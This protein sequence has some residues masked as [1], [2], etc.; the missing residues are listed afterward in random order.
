MKNSVRSFFLIVVTTFVIAALYAPKGQAISQ[1]KIEV[2]SPFVVALVMDGIALNG[3]RIPAC[4]GALIKSDVVVTAAH[5]VFKTKYIQD[6]SGL[7]VTYPGS[8]V[9]SS[10]PPRLLEVSKVLPVPTFVGVT[11]IPNSYDVDDIAFLFLKEPIPDFEEVKIADST[12]VNRAKN[13]EYEIKHYGYGIQKEKPYTLDGNPYSVIL[14]ATNNPVSTKSTTAKDERVL[15]SKGIIP[16]FATCGG[17]SGGPGYVTVS[18]VTYLVSV[19]AG[20]GGCDS[21]IYLAHTFSNLIFPHIEFFKNE[22]QIYTSQKATELKVKQEAEK[23]LLRDREIAI[24]ENT[25]YM[26]KTGC[27]WNG[28]NAELQILKGGV[29]RPLVRAKGWDFVA[30]CPSSHPVQPWTVAEIEQISQL[31]W[32]YWVVG[33]FDVF[34]S[35]FQSQL[36]AKAV[37]DLKAKQEAETEAA[38]DKAAADKAAL[39]K[40]TTITCV[41]GKLTKRVVAVKPKCPAGYKV[42]K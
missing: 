32:R 21:S 17:D 23:A 8:P 28:S 18:G 41:K 5:C 19:I 12:L 31:R 30:N 37:A 4:S 25:F 27:H 1:G 24:K 40:R 10:A 22:Y 15:Y 26:D 42:K 20:A 9:N 11:D 14:R 7:K 36:S 34:G 39:T 13:E 3:V 38:A 16:G 29:W 6:P 33:Q 2:G 35:E